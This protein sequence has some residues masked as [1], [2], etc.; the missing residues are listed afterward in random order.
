M[1]ALELGLE[2]SEFLVF[3]VGSVFAAFIVDEEGGMAVFEEGFLREIEEVDGDAVFFA[4]IR[5]RNLVEEVLSKQGD[6]LLRGEMATL[7]GHECSSARVL[8]LTLTKASS[9]SD[10][11]KT[12]RGS[13][14]RL[15]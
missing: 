2:I 10:W 1:L 9:Y 15:F 7:S 5:N 11:S 13:Q 14:Q 8:P 4:E 12:H 3:G 6:L